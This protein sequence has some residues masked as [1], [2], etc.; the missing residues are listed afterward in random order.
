MIAF[1]TYV[2]DFI[3]GNYLTITIALTLLKGWAKVSKNNTT[4]QISDLLSG[5]WN[6]TLKPFNKRGVQK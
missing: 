5:L 4:N 1:D 2:V 3:S 6:N